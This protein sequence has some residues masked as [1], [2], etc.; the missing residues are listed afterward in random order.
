[1]DSKQSQTL[2]DY[3]V[4]L[5]CTKSAY[6]SFCHCFANGFRRKS[7]CRWS[8]GGLLVL[9]KLVRITLRAAIA[10]VASNCTACEAS[11]NLSY[12]EIETALMKHYPEYDEVVSIGDR[13]EISLD[14]TEHLADAVVVGDFNSDNL[15]DFAVTISR[16]I[17]EHEASRLSA[18]HR[19]TI[20]KVAKAVVC[21]RQSEAAFQCNELTGDSLGGINADV[22]F[23]PQDDGGYGQ[24]V[25]CAD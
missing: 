17:R 2:F 9:N 8:S 22:F 18:I 24:C 1:M 19:D 10:I 14:S 6:C 13:R 20:K 16:P 11:E 23:Y 25:F 5:D 15:V 21:D 7:Y 4:R 3:A 12:E